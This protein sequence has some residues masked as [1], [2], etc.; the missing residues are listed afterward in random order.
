MSSYFCGAD[1]SYAGAFSIRC[2][3]S[4]QGIDEQILDKTN[5]Q[6]QNRPLGGREVRRNGGARRHPSSDIAT[7]CSLRSG[8]IAEPLLIKP[9]HPFVRFGGRMCERIVFSHAHHSHPA[10][11]VSMCER[12]AREKGVRRFNCIWIAA[13][14]TRK[15]TSPSSFPWNRR[16]AKG[17]LPCLIGRHT[18]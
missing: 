12:V 6:F 2:Q 17:G 15:G 7:Q 16:R 18:N 1:R 10:P 14:P 4:Y 11:R 9:Y 3:I 8:D 13:F 5:R